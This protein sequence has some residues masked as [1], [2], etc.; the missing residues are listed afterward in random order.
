LRINTAFKGSLTSADFGA[1]FSRFLAIDSSEVLLHPSVL[2]VHLKDSLQ[3]III[4]HMLQ[5]VLKSGFPSK[6]LQKFG[7]FSSALFTI[8]VHSELSPIS[9][10]MHPARFSISLST[11]YTRCTT[12]ATSPYITST[13]T[14][15]KKKHCL[16]MAI[17]SHSTIMV[18]ALTSQYVLSRVGGY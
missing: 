2:P 10:G 8:E 6:P 16:A 12:E 14:W 1:W 11:Q 3:F 13:W 5:R 18:S 9:A 7:L 15:Q 17:S 4:V